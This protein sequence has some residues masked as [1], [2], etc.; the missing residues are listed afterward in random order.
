MV[1]RTKLRSNNTVKHASGE[2]LPILSSRRRPLPQRTESGLFL[3]LLALLPSLL[4][5]QEPPEAAYPYRRDIEKYKFERAEQKLVKHL[6]RDSNDLEFNYA[7][8]QLYSTPAFEHYNTDSAY[9]HLVI[10]RRTFDIADAKMIERW[11]RDSYSGALFDHSFRRVTSMALADARGINTPDIYRH[12]LEY[13]TQAPDDIRDS[14]VRFR[15]TVEYDLALRGGTLQ[16]VEDF[17]ARR[18]Q[19]LLLPRA[20]HHRDSMVF[21]RVE[22]AHTIA[23][24]RQFRLDYPQSHLFGRATDSLYLLDY[25][26]ARR[27]DSEQYFRSYA[28]RYPQS[29][30][31]RQAIW[32]ADSIE[33]RRDVDTAQWQSLVNYADLHHR[34]SWRDTALSALTRFALAHRHLEAAHEAAQRLSSGS[35]ERADVALLLHDAYMHTSVRNF[36]RFYRRYPHLMSQQMRQRDSLAFVVSQQYDFQHADSCIR[37]VAPAHEAY[38]ML[39]QLL[40]DDIVHGHF[41]AAK[42]TA[43]RYAE[44]FGYSPEYLQLLTTLSPEFSLKSRKTRAPQPLPGA[45]NSARGNEYSPVP[46]GNGQTLY[47]AATHRPESIGGED[48]F[49]SQLTKK[50]WSQPAVVM[51]LSHTYGNEVPCAVT[52]DGNTLLLFQS[53]LL[54]LAERT[55]EGWSTTQLP[56]AINGFRQL[57]D[58]TLAANGRVLFFT[59]LGRTEREVDSSLNIYVSLLD[60]QGHWSEPH[61]I[62]A[63]IN[64]PF[65][66]RSPYLHPDMRTLYFSSEGHGSLGMMD[67][68]RTTRLDDSYTHWS[69]PVNLGHEVNSVG[70]D[71]GYAVSAD[72]RQ[73][74]FARQD[75]SQDL[76]SVALPAVAQPHPVVP[77]SGTVKDPS[78]RPVATRLEWHDPVTGRLLGQCSTHP[79]KGTFYLLLP[80]GAEYLLSMADERYRAD[81][82]VIDLTPGAP[83]DSTPVRLTFTAIPLTNEEPQPPEF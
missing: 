52:P 16:L 38:L 64:T 58:A 74:Y 76:Y 49:V 57:T 4:W 35:A 31:S 60:D 18:P 41:L 44:A 3:L 50:G 32:Y 8:Y 12:F 6:R 7:A 15:D 10:A 73:C 63:A 43:E 59:A 56:A 81:R 14:A 83:D 1:S 5:A 45:V 25:R 79:T 80:Q 78:G 46:C 51:D 33:Y 55:A 26:E 27:L 53:G 62:G 36:P 65:G 61:E 21:V 82:Q 24:Y 42:S 34:N 17:I 40:K 23:A 54:F 77:V 39:Q 72:G 37:A 68:Y 29:P 20:V 30:Y 19:S 70:D 2:S 11:A 66:E 69:A 22:Q 48:I 71:W 9:R 28:D 13:Y 47:F 75:D 67:V